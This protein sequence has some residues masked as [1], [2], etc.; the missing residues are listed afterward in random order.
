MIRRQQDASIGHYVFSPVAKFISP[1][2]GYQ[3]FADQ[4]VEISVKSYS[5][6]GDDD[7][8]FR[9]PFEFSFEVG[10][11]IGEF[12]GERLVVRRRATGRGGD[13]EAGKLLA[14]IARGRGGQEG[15]S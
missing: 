13:V 2:I 10:S 8:Q 9:Q 7:A 14:I 4:V 6:Q 12:N 15:E 11:T 1:L 5:S 3:L